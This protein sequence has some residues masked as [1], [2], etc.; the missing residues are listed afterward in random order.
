MLSLLRLERTQKNSSKPFS[1]RIFPFLSYSL[2]IETIDTFIDS[3]SSLENH[4]RFQ[5]KMGKVYI[6]FQTKTAQKPYPMGQHIPMLKKGVPLPA[7]LAV[8][9]R[10]LCLI[11]LPLQGARRKPHPLNKTPSP[12]QNYRQNDHKRGIQAPRSPPSFLI[13]RAPLELGGQR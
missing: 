3:R 4:A 7:P 1:I 8:P 12:S 13:W 11:H 6:H 5:S 10:L 2:G 9:L